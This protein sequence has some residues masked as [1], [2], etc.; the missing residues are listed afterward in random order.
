MGLA[1]WSDLAAL[2]LRGLRPE[3]PVYVTNRWILARNMTDA[4]CV[5]ILH[6]SGE[7]MPVRWLHGLDVML[8]FDSCELAGRV[9]RVMAQRD[10]QPRSMRAWCR[11]ANGFVAT[12]G[13]CDA[14][15]EPWAA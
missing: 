13:Q 3:L 4:G 2:R 10:V 14:G 12:C 9:A 8:D 5:A 6:R 7:P 11:C 1:T 15:D